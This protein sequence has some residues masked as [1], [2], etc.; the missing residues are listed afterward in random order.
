MGDNIHM[1]K[2]LCKSSDD[3]AGQ[4]ILDKNAYSYMEYAWIHSDGKNQV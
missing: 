4:R 1:E 3:C 2:A